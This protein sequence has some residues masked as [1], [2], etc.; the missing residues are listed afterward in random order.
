MINIY[1]LLLKIP[2]L[3]WSLLTIANCTWLVTLGVFVAGAVN[4]EKLKSNTAIRDLYDRLSEKLVGVP[5]PYIGV[6][7]W[8]VLRMLF[9]L[10][11]QL[12]IEL[13]L[14]LSSVTFVYRNLDRARKKVFYDL[15]NRLSES[16]DP[17][18]I[19]GTNLPEWVTFPSSQRVQWLNQTIASL[20]PSIIVATDKTMSPILERILMQYKPGMV[21]GF[22]VRGV[23]IGG[24]PM[25]INGIQNH[26][27]GMTETTLDMA[28]SWSSELDVCLLVQIPGP[29]ME[30]AVRDLSM[31][32]TI[33]VTLGPHIPDWPCFANMMISILGT[34]EINFNLK[35]AKISL[36]SVPGLGSFLDGFIRHT[37]VNLLSFPK[38]YCYTVKPGY[39]LNIGFGA[40]VLGALTIKLHSVSFSVKFLTYR[41]K[42]FYFKLGFVGSEKKRRK[43]AFYVGSDSVLTDK[44]HFALYDTTGTI[45]LWTY[46]DVTGSDVYVGSTDFIISDF[47]NS[48]H[49]GSIERT[50]IRENDVE[51]KKRGTITFSTEYRHLKGAV[52]VE[53]PPVTLPKK[54]APGQELQE[55]LEEGFAPAVPRT[56]GVSKTSAGGILFIQIDRASNLPNKEKFSTSDPYV[57]CRIGDESVTTDV[58]SSNLNPVFKFESEM[59]L[60]NVET[61][62]LKISVIDK[63]VKSDELMCTAEVELARVNHSKDKK[64]AGD[65]KLHP[66][67]TITMTLSYVPFC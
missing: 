42:K 56:R 51:Q 37:L 18:A 19:L 15:H 20:W 53:K 54:A 61:S 57:V 22:K 48:S 58:V 43:S 5:L 38:G 64:L 27:Y 50:L 35:A 34:P 21:H 25:V 45:R 8:V 30:V 17:S 49:S 65:F 7:C 4:Y 32:A 36:D 66:Q 55:M 33:R 40:G 29:D 39:P 31:R 13:F 46:F 16:K 63:N 26:Q 41:K 47:V 11:L 3:I 6:I 2:R 10:G 9:A 60:D 28:I 14:V 44:F 67:G 59:M 1:T 52:K 24:A 23:N 62:K 12:Q